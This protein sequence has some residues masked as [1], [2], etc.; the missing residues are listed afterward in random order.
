[1]FANFG[2]E[3]IFTEKIDFINSI[4]EKDTQDRWTNAKDFIANI[5]SYKRFLS[6]L[7]L[8]R[9]DSSIS[10]CLGALQV[11][12][13][14]A[15]DFIG[16]R[17]KRIESNPE[18]AKMEQEINCLDELLLL[19]LLKD[20]GFKHRIIYLHLYRNHRQSRLAVRFRPYISMEEVE[21][22]KD[23]DLCVLYHPLKRRF[24]DKSRR[25]LLKKIGYRYGL[26]NMVRE[27]LYILK[28]RIL[29]SIKPKAK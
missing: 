14:K 28:N 21:S 8:I 13:K 7:K 19:N 23:R 3:E 17:I 24:S 1:M 2:F 12:S 6:D 22:I 4:D 10:G 5:E 29:K 20:A 11:Y 26:K 27:L 16:D 25:I 18:Y 15:V 9:K